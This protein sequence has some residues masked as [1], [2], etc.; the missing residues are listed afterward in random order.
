MSKEEEIESMA[1]LLSVVSPILLHP[2]WSKLDTDNP[3]EQLQ[4]TFFFNVVEQ[5]YSR[6][7]LAFRY[8]RFIY[9]ATSPLR[10]EAARAAAARRRTFKVRLAAWLN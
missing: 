9:L 6:G 10:N 5:A 2:S 7:V 4:L 3:L 8:M 1:D